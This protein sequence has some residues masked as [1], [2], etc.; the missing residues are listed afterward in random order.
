MIFQML[1][2][3]SHLPGRRRILVNLHRESMRSSPRFKAVSDKKQQVGLAVVAGVRRVRP[4]A[5]RSCRAPWRGLATGIVS[6]SLRVDGRSRPAG[7][8]VVKGQAGCRGAVSMSVFAHT[9]TD[10]V[11][12]KSDALDTTAATTNTSH[13]HTR[14]HSVRALTAWLKV[15]A[16]ATT[17]SEPVRSRSDRAGPAVVRPTYRNQQRTATRLPPPEMA[18]SEP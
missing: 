6:W 9:P 15:R 5:D 12:G 18:E 13:P 16:T 1:G 17:Q 3:S 4:S 2:N 11:Q 7:A 10:R 14:Q 8:W